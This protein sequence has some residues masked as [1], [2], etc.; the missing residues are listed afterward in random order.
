VPTTRWL[1]PSGLSAIWI[2][3][4][5]TISTKKISSAPATT[6]ASPT[7]SWKQTSVSTSKGQDRSEVVFSWQGGEPTLLGLD[8]FHKVVELEQKYK[9]PNQRIE[10]DLQPNG[11]LLNDE[12]GAFL[13]QH[14][15]LVPL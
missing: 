13:K 5:V 7:K 1:N 6:S 3:P 9:K 2:A 15:F 12:W 11:T 14:G 10:N 8:F 4:T